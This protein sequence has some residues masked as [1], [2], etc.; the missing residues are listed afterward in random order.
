MKSKVED[1]VFDLE[2]GKVS[3]EKEKMEAINEDDG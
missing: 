1:L 2:T 3:K